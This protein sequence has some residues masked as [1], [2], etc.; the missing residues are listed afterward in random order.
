MLAHS[1]VEA[2]HRKCMPDHGRGRIRAAALHAWHNQ[3]DVSYQPLLHKFTTTLS[4]DGECGSAEGQDV[5][6]RGERNRRTATIYILQGSLFM[7]KWV[8]SRWEGVEPSLVVLKHAESVG[9]GST[10]PHSS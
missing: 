5:S 4:T 3:E 6:G 8:E 10:P 2:L 7:L 9:E 1:G